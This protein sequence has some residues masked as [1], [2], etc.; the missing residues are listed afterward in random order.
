MTSRLMTLIERYNKGETT[1]VYTEIMALGSIALQP[2]HFHKVQAVLAETMHR[3][4]NNLEVIDR[5][6]KPSA[7]GFVEILVMI[8]NIHC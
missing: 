7:M 8:L 5:R 2:P 6:C 1:Q 3:V 4:T